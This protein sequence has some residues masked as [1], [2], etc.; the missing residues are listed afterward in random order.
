MT[1]PSEGTPNQGNNTDVRAGE[2]ELGWRAALPD[3]LKN[4]DFVKSFTKPGDAI[5]D[6]VRVKQESASYIKPLTE[7]STPEEKAAFYTKLGRPESPDKYD[8]K[9]PEG[10]PDNA[11]SPEL[12]AEFR[13]FVFEK[14]LSK[15]AAT[16]IY[17]WYNEKVKGSISAMSAKEASDAETTRQAT[18]AAVDKLRGE[19]K[20]DAFDTNK[21]I[22]VKAFKLFT[23][24]NEE[25]ARIVE[26]AKVDG[27]Q[28][29]NHPVFLKL[30]HEIGK[31][32]SN[33]SALLK[34]EG[35]SSPVLSQEEQ[36][37][38]MFPSMVKKAG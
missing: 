15:Q 14:G 10:I 17:N 21:A 12:E 7:Q 6:Y 27:V 11:Y 28:L 37:G 34:N 2:S 25:A 20:G 5:R 3:D 19:W 38:K 23:K 18:E 30:F 9:R 29:G 31:L 16:D 35:M 13:K 8:F 4:H 22:A 36:A 24:G 1:M 32:T 26:T 33:D